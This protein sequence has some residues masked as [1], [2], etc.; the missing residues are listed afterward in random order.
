M[1]LGSKNILIFSKVW[2]APLPSIQMF[3]DYPTP[4]EGGGYFCFQ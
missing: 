3:N 1:N 2:V 4:G